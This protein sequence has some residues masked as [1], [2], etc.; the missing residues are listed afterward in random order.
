MLRLGLR[1]IK[2]IK[3]LFEKFKEAFFAVFP[4]AA[5]VLVL[6]LTVAKA[7]FFSIISFIIATILLIIGMTFFTLGADVSMMK[8]GQSI[9]SHITKSRSILLTNG[10]VV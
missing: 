6:S 9:G 7:S 8:I 10:V 2:L 3:H 4:V 5:I 1:Y